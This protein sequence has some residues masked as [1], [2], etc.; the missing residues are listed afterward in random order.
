MPFDVVY[1][2]AAWLY[3]AN[4]IGVVRD[5]MR[6]LRADGVARIDA[7]EVRDGLP[8]EYARLVEIWENGA[9][10]PLGEYAQRHGVAL[11]PA[12]EGHF[13]HFGRTPSFGRDVERVIEIDLAAIHPDW[14]GIKCVYR[15]MPSPPRSPGATPGQGTDPGT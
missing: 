9:L 5:V 2:Q 3:F 13:L 7:D 11:A 8:A 12:P 15:M 1:S 4:K 6:V 10:V 14:D